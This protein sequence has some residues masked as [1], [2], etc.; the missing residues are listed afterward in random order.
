MRST[1]MANPATNAATAQ[2][3]AIP[4]PTSP[5]RWRSPGSPARRT[6]PPRRP[7]PRGPAWAVAAGQAG[8]S[9]RRRPAPGR[10]SFAA[11]GSPR[12]RSTRQARA[13]RAARS[14]GHP[15]RPAHPRTRRPRVSR[16]ARP[17][18]GHRSARPRRGPPSAVRAA[19][20]F[21]SS[22]PRSPARRTAARLTIAGVTSAL[23]AGPVLLVFPVSRVPLIFPVQPAGLN[24]P[25]VPAARACSASPIGTIS[26]GCSLRLVG[27]V[28]ARRPGD[29]ML[30]GQRRIETGDKVTPRRILVALSAFG[31]IPVR[32][33]P[34][35]ACR[36]LSST[37][38]LPRSAAGRINR[39]IGSPIRTVIRRDPARTPRC[40]R[41]SLPHR[42]QGWP[43]D[44]YRDTRAP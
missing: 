8:C 16:S 17:R 41:R 37:I 43:R 39:G 11:P 36:S 9:A 5:P 32:H 29:G 25:V 33:V 44:S 22:A 24:R 12:D 1:R 6:A 13:S 42:C 10:G 15:L 23:P 35:A 27:Y 7:W 18:R 38:S 14:A 21:R 4:T 28:F 19:V 2:N 31:V 40:P 3:A 30:R 20:P 34:T 26:V